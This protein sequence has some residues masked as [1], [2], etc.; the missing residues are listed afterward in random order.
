MFLPVSL[1]ARWRRK[2]WRCPRRN[3][4]LLLLVGTPLLVRR[5]WLTRCTSG[6]AN[7]FLSAMGKGA[8]I[9]P[10]ACS[11][12]PVHAQLRLALALIN[13]DAALTSATAATVGA[14]TCLTTKDPRGNLPV[15]RLC[16]VINV[17]QLTFRGVCDLPARWKGLLVAVGGC[18][19]HRLR[20]LRETDDGLLV[21]GSVGLN[22]T[23]G[24][25][26]HR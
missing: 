15:G 7:Q 14:E 26:D 23:S 11:A 10:R 18:V 5:S 25:Y 20:Q 17:V 8:T 19:R 3:L 16:V 12:F 9:T 24:I 1:G 6:L 4:L 22:G 13:P 21:F 2:T